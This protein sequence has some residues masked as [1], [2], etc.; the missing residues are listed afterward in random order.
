MAT[1]TSLFANIASD[2]RLGLYREA[3][4]QPKAL[5]EFL[6]LN[7]NEV[8]QVSGIKKS[9]VRYDALIPAQMLERL[10]EIGN[11]CNLVAAHFNGDA[12]KTA[13]WFK[14]KNPLL[15][16]VSPRDMIRFGRYDRLRRFVISAIANQSRNDAAKERAQRTAVAT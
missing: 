16:D 9:S 8:S 1:S 15:G 7:N 11:I 14:T 4:F 5:V 2:D 12:R 6:K 3:V 13:L 10:E